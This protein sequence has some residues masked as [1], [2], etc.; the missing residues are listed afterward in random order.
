MNK[1]F[2]LFLVR[3]VVSTLTRR[4]FEVDSTAEPTNVEIEPRIVSITTIELGRSEEPLG[5]ERRK[6]DNSRSATSSVRRL[7]A[8]RT[9]SRKSEILFEKATKGSGSAGLN[10]YGVGALKAAAEKSFRESL[11]LSGEEQQ[12]FEEGIEVT[13]PARTTVEVF[14]HWKAIWQEGLLAIEMGDGETYKIPYRIMV[15]MTFD[16]ENCDA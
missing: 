11:T 4:Y 13:V 9:W 2:E 7:R 1:V 15:G 5:A 10:I 12:T 14:L 6:I 3:A 8:Q 16:Q